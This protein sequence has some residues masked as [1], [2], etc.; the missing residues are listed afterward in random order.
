M[1]KNQE[2]KYLTASKSKFRLILLNQTQ[3]ALI[4]DL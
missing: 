4:N 1:L 2:S 3:Q